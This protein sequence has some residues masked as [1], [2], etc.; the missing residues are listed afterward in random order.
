MFLLN[1]VIQYI[2]ILVAA[3][4]CHR[5]LSNWISGSHI[6]FPNFEYYL[7]T[8]ISC[9]SIMCEWWL[10][11]A[12]FFIVI[13]KLTKKLRKIV[14]ICLEVVQTWFFCKT[15]IW[16]LVQFGFYLEAMHGSLFFFLD[17]KTIHFLVGMLYWQWWIFFFHS[18]L[19]QNLFKK[20]EG[21]EFSR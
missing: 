7:I 14:D 18:V 12:R 16:K 5:S 10:K 8:C 4:L 17:D 13:T 1:V 19:K 15:I 21:A 2:Y 9:K 6:Y 11:Y 20:I 3:S